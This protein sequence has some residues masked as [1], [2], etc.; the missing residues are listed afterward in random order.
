M[1][2]KVVFFKIY[3][4]VRSLSVQYITVIFTVLFFFAYSQR[5]L[6]CKDDIRNQFKTTWPSHGWKKIPFF[7]PFIVLTWPVLKIQTHDGV[8]NAFWQELIEAD[9]GGQEP[10]CPLFQLKSMTEGRALL[11]APL[12]PQPLCAPPP[13]L[14]PACQD[15]LPGSRQPPD[16]FVVPNNLKK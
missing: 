16:V 2:R 15:A 13:P 4:F 3:F 8:T 10:C 7:N 1:F 9:G 6:G 14:P 11:E 5:I 12:P